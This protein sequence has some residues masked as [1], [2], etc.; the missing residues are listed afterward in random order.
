MRFS[1]QHIIDAVCALILV[2][3]LLVPMAATQVYQQQANTNAI[4]ASA[5]HLH[6]ARPASR[7]ARAN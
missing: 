6:A 1:T 4:T 3:V 5:S 7:A 2:A